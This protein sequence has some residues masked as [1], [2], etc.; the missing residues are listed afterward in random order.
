MQRP[1]RNK[2]KIVIGVTGSFG[3][4]KSTVSAILRSYGAYLIDADKIAR[5]VTKQGAGV[6]KK[7]VKAFGR[8]IL[9][10]NK[11]IDRRKLAGIVFDNNALLEKLNSLLHP[12]AIRRIKKEIKSARNKIVVL[13]APLLVEAGLKKLVNKLIVVRIAKNIQIKRIQKKTS[14]NK[15]EILKIIKAQISLSDKVRL[16]DF[17]IDNNGTIKN[18][19]EQVG[20]IRRRLWR[21]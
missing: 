8:E 1:S 18:T 21:N 19:K 13:D 14:L 17:I 7:I 2:K 20:Q 11:A 4:G 10:E 15:E 6:Y 16:A 3:S 9:K 5:D 12:E